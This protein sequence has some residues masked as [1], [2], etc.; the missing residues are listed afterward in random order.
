MAQ[1]LLKLSAVSKYYVGSQ[2]V[3]M[4]L[5]R[6]DLSL[7]R[8]EFVAITGESGSGKSTLA[9][10]LGGI[11]PYEDG[12]LY[13]NG[14]PTSHYD[15]AD[16]EQYRRENISFISQN[17]GILPGATV[18]D[19]VISA[20]RLSGM[21]KERARLECDAILNQVDLLELKKQRAA[22]LSSGQKQRLSIARA[23]AKP[24]PVL[25]A[26]EPTGNLDSENSRKVIALLAEAAKDRLVILITHEFQ[27]AQDHATRHIRIQEGKVTSD[28]P[29][30]PSNE[31]APMPARDS[32]R[33]RL[34]RYIAGLQISSRPVFFSLMLLFC[35]LTA[36][37]VF[38][39]LGTFI[40]NLDDSFTRIY[41]DSAFSNGSDNRIVA[42]RRDNAVMTEADYDAILSVEHVVAVERYG[43]A[44]DLYCSYREG[45][46][47]KTHY[48]LEN[49]GSKL[50]AEFT[51]NSSIEVL[52]SSSFVKTVPLLADGREFLKDGRLPEN[53]YEVI[54]ADAS[55]PVGTTLP[56]FIR[57]N[58]NWGYNEYIYMEVTVVGTTGFGSGLYFHDDMGTMVNYS[59]TR[60]GPNSWAVYAP[61]YEKITPGPSYKYV[62][63][64]NGRP[65]IVEEESAHPSAQP[66]DE[67]G[68]RPVC[69]E[70]FIP[71]ATFLEQYGDL[72]ALGA[73]D[74]T[75]YDPDADYSEGYPP[76]VYFA[77]YPAGPSNGS[78]ML[79]FVLVSDNTFRRVC[80]DTGC[81]Q[82]SLTIEDFAYT[83]RVIDALYALG[84]NS[85]SPY[86][87]GTTH[88]DPELA[89][90]RMQTLTVCLAALAAVILLQSIVLR[91]MFSMETESYRLLSHIGLAS[92]TACASIAW[93]LAAVTAAGQLIGLAAVFI[94]GQLGF[95]RI[96]SMLHY[97]P[98]LYFVLLSLVHWLS[99]GAAYLW[100]RQTL[101]KQVYP[102][103]GYR[104]D[105]EL[106]VKEDGV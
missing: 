33:Q 50:D 54:S 8:G 51:K 58:H 98:W 70:E 25:I 96:V 83:Q 48:S 56:V 99:I 30:R 92:D 18:Q 69:D 105:L 12:E 84:Y 46:D 65:M 14:A 86:Q 16:W 39:F 19:N 104:G 11:L 85:V 82:V 102:L 87:Q 93:Q 44:A 73:L 5:N 88:Q 63:G 21:S 59:F 41:D 40:V 31:A 57:D 77:L 76:G 22:R 95:E 24:T 67:N 97:L 23:L 61:Y 91:A 55:V 4:G 38:A 78:T 35:V 66:L 74:R 27:E 52:K 6:V 2:S 68:M 20:L 64:D 89:A 29:L 43:Y 79:E 36:F 15:S 101:K 45:F 32:L 37:A 100:V 81:N 13:F 106:D 1:P 75:L 9:H 17:Y 71:S 34:D 103:S 60:G 42:V 10:I 80:P 53:I 90:Q 47:Y 62:L 3:T 72:Q 94:S 7:D 28:I 26:D 49:V